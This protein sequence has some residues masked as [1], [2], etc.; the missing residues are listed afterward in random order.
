MADKEEK[1]GID[2]IKKEM[3]EIKQQVKAVQKE[4]EEAIAKA[5]EVENKLKETVEKLTQFA[6]VIKVKDSE[7][8]TT[9]IQIA[10]KDGKLNE[11]KKRDRLAPIN[12]WYA[13]QTDE[14]KKKLEDLSVSSPDDV[15]NL[16][17]AGK[18]KVTEPK[19]EEKKE[20]KT[21][22]PVTQMTN[23]SQ[24]ALLNVQEEKEKKDDKKDVPIDQIYSAENGYTQIAK[25][26]GRNKK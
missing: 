24:V 19:K 17:V 13:T 22:P 7:A 2:A 11:Y 15:W 1:D 20:A 21:T 9:K 25:I 12:E 8:E 10:E 26:L 14:T 23:V 18:E 6:E 16:I 3:S 5:S 4:K